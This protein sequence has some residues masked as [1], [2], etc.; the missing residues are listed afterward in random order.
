MHTVLWIVLALGAAAVWSY[1]VVRRTQGIMPRITMPAGESLPMTAMQRVAWQ[2]LAPTLVLT[3]AAAA[4]VAYHGVEVA[5][6]NDRVRLTVTVLLIAA[7][8]GY[9]YFITRLRI[10]LT[11]DEGTLDERD[12][13]IL[14]SAPAGQAPAMMVALAAWMISLIE[15]YHAT[16]LVPSAYLYAIFWTLLM[17]SILASLLGVLI[18]YRR[19]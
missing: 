19:T 16:H 9:T 3:F 2:A 5:W 18:G 10:W 11:R 14:A 1:M 17:V 15:R 4:M 12:R 7:L 13:A 8:G 6:D